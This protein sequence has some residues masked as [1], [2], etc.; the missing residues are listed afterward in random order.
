MGE[1]NK[2]IALGKLKDYETH[3]ERHD[4]AQVLV[5]EKKFFQAVQLFRENLEWSLA[6]FGQDHATTVYDQETLASAVCQLAALNEAKNRGKNNPEAKLRVKVL[7]QEAR[8]LD[9]KALETRLRIEGTSKGALETQR[10]LASDYMVLEEY[11]KAAELLRKNYDARRNHPEFGEDH[12]ETLQAGYDLAGCWNKLWK[13]E[14]ARALNQKILDARIRLGKPEADIGKSRNAVQLNNKRIEERKKK[15]EQADKKAAEGGKVKSS[16]AKD[17]DKGP[18]KNDQPAGGRNGPGAVKPPAWRPPQGNDLTQNNSQG[19]RG[20]GRG[21]N[22]AAKTD[23]TT[24]AQLLEIPY[25]YVD[26]R[27]SGINQAGSDTSSI[28]SGSDGSKS[29]P[30]SFRIGSGPRNRPPTPH[31]VDADPDQGPSGFRPGSTWAQRY[32]ESQATPQTPS[33]YLKPTDNNPIKEGRPRAHSTDRGNG[34]ENSKTPPHRRARSASPPK[35]GKQFRQLSDAGPGR[36]DEGSTNAVNHWFYLLKE[37]TQGLLSPLRRTRCKR[38]KIAVLDTGIDI[39]HPSFAAD[40]AG[41]FSSR[42]IKSREDFLDPGGNAHD[43][44]GHGTHCASLFRRI[45]PEADIYIARVAKDFDADLSADVVA[46]AILRACRTGKD[47]EGKKNWGVDIIS[48]SFGFYG[49][50][51][52]VQTAI[53]EAL[54]KPV[55]LFAAASNN[56]TMKRV[57]FPAWLS[58]VICVNSAAADGRPSGFN[59]DPKPLQNFSILGENIKGAWTRHPNNYESDPNVERVMTG[60]SVAT[61]MMAGVAAL[62]LEF[63]LQND[64]ESVLIEQLEDLKHQ[65]GM[66]EVFV[67]MLGRQGRFRNVV[68]WELLS[69]QNGR[70]MVTQFLMH[71]LRNFR[72]E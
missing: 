31:I 54:A 12:E 27:A 21:F 16:G 67:K 60:T 38:V 2:S 45:A 71:A 49:Y 61:P 53:T 1:L 63:V 48:M 44:C 9:E 29:P 65:D 72:G 57:T 47:E 37:E 20:R 66:P 58:G 24:P 42:R 22:P 36:T 56:G 41:D 13:Y 51:K 19:G 8:D 39:G 17:N 14:M 55:L 26:P 6:N 23:T 18:G 10:S 70:P 4:K 5:D 3:K 64:P 59:P 62:V 15:R 43:I 46:K 34:N 25:K 68:P 30:M 35:D 11:N 50:S 69:T 40:Q 32:Q 52:A 7:Y 33:D 28:K